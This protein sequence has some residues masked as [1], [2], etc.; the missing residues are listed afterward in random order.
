MADWSQIDLSGDPV[1]VVGLREKPGIVKGYRVTVDRNVIPGFLE[2]AT[3]TLDR[4]SAMTPVEYTPYVDPQEDEYLTLSPQALVVTS[5]EPAGEGV[6]TQRQQT[7]HL[8]DLVRQADVLPELGAGQLIDRLKEFAVQAICPISDGDRIGF[9][10]KASARQVMKRSA[11]PLGKDDRTDRF[12]RIS[13]PEVVLEGDIH[14]VMSSDEIAILN[15]PQFQ[16]MVSDIGLVNRY[17]PA[18]V[19]RIAGR[20]ANRGIPLSGGAQAALQAKALGSVQFAKRLDALADRVE[21][22]DAG[23]I[24]SGAGFTAQDLDANDFVNEAGEIVCDV[25][26]AVELVDALEGRFFGDAFTAEKRRADSLR[27]RRS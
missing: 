5:E 9:V 17:A 15:K 19:A 2:V 16:F 25:G 14:A 12:K 4:L 27:K 6:P 8:L 11:I 1:L 18:Q 13:R 10:T 22:V 3:E 26:R 7:A 23:L 24:S 21:Q 20:M